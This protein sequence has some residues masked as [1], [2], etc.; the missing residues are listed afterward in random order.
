MEVVITKAP[1][2]TTQLLGGSV[3][4]RCIATG[5]PLPTITWS[6]DNRK[7]I[8]PSNETRLDDITIFS[9]ILL[10]NIRMEDFVNY[11]CSARNGFNMVNASAALINA[12][13]FISHYK[14]KCLSHNLL[15]QL[16]Q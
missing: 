1:M 4:F 10:A 5:I 8:D 9:E 14:I 16:Y 11:T 15:S 6:S 12:S 2:E 3:T 13:M 7:M